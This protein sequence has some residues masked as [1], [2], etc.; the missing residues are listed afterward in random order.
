[1]IIIMIMQRKHQ[2]NKN[3]LITKIERKTTEWKFQDTNNRNFT[4]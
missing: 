3:N 4:R 2:Q 1:M